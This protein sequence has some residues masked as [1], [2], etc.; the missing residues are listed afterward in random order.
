MVYFP[1]S[2][3][4]TDCNTNDGGDTSNPD[5]Q[6]NGL[7]FSQYPPTD[8][9]K[10]RVGEIKSGTT[11]QSLRLYSDLSAIVAKMLSI[12]PVDRVEPSYRNQGLSITLPAEED[13]KFGSEFPA[14]VNASFNRGEWVNAFATPGGDAVTYPPFYPGSLLVVNCPI[15]GFDG[16]NGENI[17]TLA[18][19]DSTNV[20]YYSQIVNVKTYTDW[21]P[22]TLTVSMT[23]P[24]EP[25]MPPVYD[26]KGTEYPAPLPKTFDRTI[27]YNVYKPVFLNGTEVT[28]SQSGSQ[29]RRGTV[30]VL[31]ST[32]EIIY[33]NHNYGIGEIYEP[34]QIPFVPQTVY[35]YDDGISNKW[36][37]VN[38]TYTQ[39]TDYNNYGDYYQVELNRVRRIKLLDVKISVI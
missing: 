7:L 32:T 13:V 35:E 12:G 31:K 18:I 25:S 5:D 37:P 14:F 16:T 28:K 30:K 6:T 9:V 2:S 24:S 4:C 8:I 21:E 39:L 11:V 1:F 20:I 15:L 26:N 19:T 10:T 33:V 38:F 29:V 3:S 22:V 23:T 17:V 34:M 36:N 27:R